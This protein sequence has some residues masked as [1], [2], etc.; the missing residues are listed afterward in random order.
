LYLAEPPSDLLGVI[1][2]WKARESAWSHLALIVF[3]FLS[4]LA[5]SSECERVF[6]SCGK[7][8]TPESSRLS[9]QMLWHTERLKNWQR[10]GAIKIESFKNARLL[11]LSWNNFLY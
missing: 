2:Y 1:E 9:G 10:M 7:Q 4:I 3:H 6:S 11:D 8:T 5:M